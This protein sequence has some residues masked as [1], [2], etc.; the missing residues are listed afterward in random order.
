MELNEALTQFGLT[1]KEARIYLALLELGSASV[2]KI[3]QKA[4]IARATAYDILES[5]KNQQLAS[6]FEKGATKYY[7]PTDPTRIRVLARQKNEIIEDVFPQLKALYGLQS[8]KP[9]V[10]FYE[11]KEGMKIIL[12]ENLKDAQ[13]NFTFGSAE[14]LFATLDFFPEFVKKRVKLK[15]PVKVIL[16]ESTKARERQKL[17]PKELREVRIIPAKY[18]FHAMT[19]IFGNKIAMFSFKKTF[20]ALLIESEELAAMQKMMFKLIWDGLT[21][22]S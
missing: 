17:G 20:I 1:E 21:R 13:E 4:Q 6:I 3:A 12:E 18:E 9:K 19:M 7:S 15:I 14:D 16:R 2:Q 10:R 22:T 11:G 8:E 5:L